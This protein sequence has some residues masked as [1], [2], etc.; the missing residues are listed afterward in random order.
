MVQQQAGRLHEQIAE[1]AVL[2]EGNCGKV[3]LVPAATPALPN[4]VSLGP[5]PA[6]PTLVSNVISLTSH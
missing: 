2:G 3:L 6:L 1:A 4:L 5:T